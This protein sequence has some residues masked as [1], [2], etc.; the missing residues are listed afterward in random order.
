MSEDEDN[1]NQS[2]PEEMQLRVCKLQSQGF[3]PRVSKGRIVIE[4]QFSRVFDFNRNTITTFLKPCR[5]RMD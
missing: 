3:N 5:K 4:G 1:V 2:D